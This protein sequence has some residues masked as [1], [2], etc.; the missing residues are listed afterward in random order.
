MVAAVAEEEV[1]VAA[2]AVKLG[3][4]SLPLASVSGIRVGLKWAAL[5]KQSGQR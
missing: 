2:A 4:P 1:E 3:H 5:W